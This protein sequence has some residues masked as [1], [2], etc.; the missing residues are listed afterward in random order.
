MKLPKKS[1]QCFIVC[2]IFLVFIGLLIFFCLEKAQ[3]EAKEKELL[4]EQTI[5]EIENTNKENILVQKRQVNS[6]IINIVYSKHDGTYNSYFLNNTNGAIVS[7][8]ELIKPE[9]IEDF[10]QKVKELIFLKY[11]NF[12]AE[13]LIKEETKTAYEMRD[14]ELVLHFTNNTITP[15]P[16]EELF[17]KINY[18]EIKEDLNFT[19]PLSEEYEN[20][21]GYHYDKNKKT[22]AITFDDGP[23]G[24]N[25]LQLMESLKENKMHATFFM[26]GNRMET[27]PDVVKKTL[28]YGNEIGSHTYSHANLNR[29][30]KDG[31]LIEAN[32]TNQAYK[33][34]TGT[35][36]KLLRPPY[37]NINSLVKETLDYSFVNWSLD[38]EDWRYRNAEHI[39][40]EVLNNVE[41]GD[42]VLMHDLYDTT[43]EAIKKLL[44]ELYVRGYQV[45][46]V[47][48]LASLKGVN[49]ELK[50]VIRS[51]K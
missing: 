12:I 34:I 44:P 31:I 17:L 3:N 49:L 6:Y 42:I 33:N 9:K 38:T 28:E 13:N 35:N 39:Y 30:D 2:V 23:S 47:T 22:I 40:N 15:H 45:V 11:P 16:S 43:T 24:K 29:L 7:V 14:T 32:K 50:K 46:T 10:N 19:V 5:L 1:K 37:G 36:L 18:N 41:D 27:F 48:E 21:N 8:E 4:T 20:E 25:T 51:I 26:V